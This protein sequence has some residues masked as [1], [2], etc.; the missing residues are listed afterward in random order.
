MTLL[1][2]SLSI[3]VTKNILGNDGGYFAPVIPGSHFC[4]NKQTHLKS[5]S[6]IVVDELGTRRGTDSAKHFRDLATRKV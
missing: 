4:I 3:S 5:I 1:R 2:L 6:Q